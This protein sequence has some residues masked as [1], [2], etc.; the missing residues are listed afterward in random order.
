MKNKNLFN[1]VLTILVAITVAYFI[2]LLYGFNIISFDEKEVVI[3]HHNFKLNESFKD[4]GTTGDTIGGIFGPIISI[5]ASI[6]TYWALMEQVEAN[7]KQA[8]QFNTQFLEQ[9]KDNFRN[10]FFEMLKF[11][12]EKK[13]EAFKLEALVSF[14]GEV[15]FMHVAYNSLDRDFKFSTDQYRCYKHTRD[16]TNDFINEVQSV[17][18]GCKVAILGTKSILPESLP[19][20]ERKLIYKL[21]NSR[22]E[23]F[24]ENQQF[25]DYERSNYE[26]AFFAYYIPNE[27]GFNQN[28]IYT[29]KV[30]DRNTSIFRGN[31]GIIELLKNLKNLLLF[32]YD[33]KGLS[34][35]EKEFYYSFLI[36]QFTQLELLALYLIKLAN[37]DDI[38]P[39]NVLIESKF[40]RHLNYNKI[41]GYV[42]PKLYFMQKYG[43]KIN[44]ESFLEMHSILG[45]NQSSHT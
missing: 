42:N 28:F 39:D 21:A 22:P 38:F 17:L 11:F 7:K 14:L 34:K 12:M 31:S 40:F 23:A 43:D 35:E 10:H 1:I 15:N 19:E 25:H 2:V 18:L 29:L 45:D 8:E 33:S 5:I 16:E 26:P 41:N 6:L 32:I 36:T 9:Q 27:S 44:I 24:S 13:K 20:K 3:S 30:K 4:S 37:F